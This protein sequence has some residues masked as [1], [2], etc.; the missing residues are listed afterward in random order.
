MFWCPDRQWHGY[1]EVEVVEYSLSQRLKMA[2]YGRQNEL[3]A[4][5][6]K[7]GVSYRIDTPQELMQFVAFLDKPLAEI[8]DDFVPRSFEK[9]T[10]VE[11]PGPTR[12]INPE[13]FIRRVVPGLVAVPKGFEIGRASC[14][15]RVF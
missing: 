12:Y 8:L 10:F 15:E 14:R 6:K 11:L 3:R 13:H 4:A 7:F 2:N 9:H 1:N 5:L